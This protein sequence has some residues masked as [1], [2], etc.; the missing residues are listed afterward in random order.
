[1]V[2]RELGWLREYAREVRAWSYFQKV[3]KVAEE[4]IKEAGL[5]RTSWRRAQDAWKEKAHRREPRTNFET[6]L[7]FVRKEE[8][9]CLQAEVPGSTDV[10]ESLFGKY[11][12]LPHKR[13]AGRSRRMC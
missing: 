2:G 11:K 9:R 5:S 12:D 4:E 13:P 6:G 1:M 10:L 3:V 7:S 8:P